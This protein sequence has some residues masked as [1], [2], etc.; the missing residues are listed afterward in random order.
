M[1]NE[2]R[3]QTHINKVLGG[4][5]SYDDGLA[6]PTEPP[7]GGELLIAEMERELP[8]LCPAPSQ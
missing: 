5:T 3:K 7:E 2:E 4:M 8:H 6:D 1:T